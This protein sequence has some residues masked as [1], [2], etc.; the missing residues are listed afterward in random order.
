MLT[1]SFLAWIF[2]EKYVEKQYLNKMRSTIPEMINFHE[3]F[4]TALNTAANSRHKS[5]IDEFSG[6]LLFRQSDFKRI[7]LKFMRD[8][9]DIL[10]LL[11]STT[12]HEKPLLDQFVKSKKAQN[13]DILR[14]ARHA[15]LEH[16]Q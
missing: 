15:M 10:H 4:V 14:F 7:Y 5:V 3:D 8:Y 12:F 1:L 9:G 13:Q 2:R 11:G 6:F 16:A